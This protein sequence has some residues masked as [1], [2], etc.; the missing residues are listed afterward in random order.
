[1]KNCDKLKIQFKP[2]WL[3]RQRTYAELNKLPLKIAIYWRRIGE[4]TLVDASIFCN[5]NKSTHILKIEKAMM[6]NEMAILGDVTLGTF[7]PLQIRIGFSKEKTHYIGNNEWH[8]IVESADMF[9]RGTQITEELERSIAFKMMMG[10]SLKEETEITFREDGSPEFNIF[11]Y[12]KIEKD[13][14]DDLGFEIVGS[15]SRIISSG[16]MHA[17]E[18]KDNEENT[19]LIMPQQE[20]EDFSV[21]IPENYK[22]TALPLWRLIQKPNEDVIM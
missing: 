16:Y 11:T 2:D 19:Q 17:T 12:D 1:M 15:V 4:W 8:L 14:R 22:G 13:E 7:L 10:G 18:W 3:K 5:H 21:F 9:C 6:L 20:P